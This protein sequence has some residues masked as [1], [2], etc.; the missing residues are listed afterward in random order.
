MLTPQLSEASLALLSGSGL[1]NLEEGMRTG[2]L[3]SRQR[4]FSRRL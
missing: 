3:V 4:R 2:G 1:A